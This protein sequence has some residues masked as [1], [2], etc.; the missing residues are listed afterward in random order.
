MKRAV[1][2]FFLINLFSQFL[3]SNDYTCGVYYICISS[4]NNIQV[5]NFLSKFLL[6]GKKRFGETGQYASSL[7]VFSNCNKG[8]KW[9]SSDEI[10]LD[11][12]TTCALIKI[13]N[14]VETLSEY[15]TLLNT[16]KLWKIGECGVKNGE[17][18]CDDKISVE[19]G[20]FYGKWAVCLSS[21]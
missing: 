15:K 20:K 5:N 7:S 4:C 3:Y 2:I 14:S 9:Y 16:K 17:Y 11:T 8:C 13:D 1:I 10:I 19:I 12:S 21:K 18:F 6:K